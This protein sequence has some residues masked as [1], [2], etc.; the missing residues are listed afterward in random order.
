MADTEISTSVR[1]PIRNT[2]VGLGLVLFFPFGF[3]IGFVYLLG[4]TARMAWP[5]Q[6]PADETPCGLCKHFYYSTN[7]QICSAA[8]LYL[9]GAR[10][11]FLSG[12]GV[13]CTMWRCK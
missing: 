11:Q 10:K 13:Q 8:A 2:L 12:D 3:A 6:T 7:Q 4:L 9:P 1:R 5:V